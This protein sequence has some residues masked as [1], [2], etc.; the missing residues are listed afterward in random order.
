MV[1]VE[2]S[3]EHAAVGEQQGRLI[4]ST[5]PN[6][7]CV[8]LA[9]S[10]AVALAIGVASTG[11][12]QDASFPPPTGDPSIIPDGAKLELLFDDACFIGGVATS[13]EG[14]VYFSDITFTSGCRHGD[15]EL[16]QAGIIW[17]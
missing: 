6:Y 1:A 9:G 5:T 10:M 15:S 13:P 16:A 3:A 17:R 8:A 4:V 2:P 14:H 12:T 11:W 7:G